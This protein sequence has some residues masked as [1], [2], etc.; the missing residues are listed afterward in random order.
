MATFIGI[1]TEDHR[2][3]DGSRDAIEEQSASRATSAAIEA[4]DPGGLSAEVRFERDI[5]LHHLRLELFD[6][7]DHRHWERRST[8]MD[9]IGD[10]ALP[11]CSRAT[12]RRSRSGSTRST[13]RLEAVPKFLAEHRTRPR[14]PQVRLWQEIELKSGER[15]CRAFFD[16][17]VRG[18]CGRLAPTK[19]RRLGAAAERAKVAV[20]DYEA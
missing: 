20:A 17:I 18:R 16:E 5:E 2:L 15:P 1:H 11:A 19:Q 3:P 4:I 14:G 8:A 13:A 12:T 9:G 7:R 10:A 6:A